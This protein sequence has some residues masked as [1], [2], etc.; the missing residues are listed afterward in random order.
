M[1]NIEALVRDA[2]PH[3]SRSPEVFL[4][5]VAVSEEAAVTARPAHRR[6]RIA[7]GVSLAAVLAVS[8]GAV[9][10]ADMRSLWWSTPHEVH[11]EA[12][13]VADGLDAFTT[14]SFIPAVGYADG[15]DADTP[16]AQQAFQA[17]QTW[18]TE[19]PF[20]ADVPPRSQVVTE[21][22]REA[23]PGKPNSII[24]QDKA[25]LASEDL[26]R[27]DIG[28]RGDRVEADLR[29]HLASNGIEDGLIVVDFVHGV[30]EVS[31]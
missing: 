27:A 12:E 26:I 31:R 1:S 23:A 6:K 7:V 16:G 15:V 5:A 10:T 8:G 25:R 29:A 19:H 21:E 18:F 20:T 28:D 17:A 3:A 30:Y 9:A 2:A 11:A 22:D 13:P 24:L 14:V 4:A